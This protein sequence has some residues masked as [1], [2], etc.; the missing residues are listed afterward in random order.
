MMD[1]VSRIAKK[2]ARP[3]PTLSLVGMFLSIAAPC[4]A[5][6]NC[7]V[8]K[9]EVPPLPAT[10]QNPPQPWNGTDTGIVVDG[11]VGLTGVK[12]I[13]HGVDLSSNN[14]IN[15]DNIIRCGGQFAFLRLD[16]SHGIDSLYDRHRQ[17]LAEHGWTIFP[18]AYFALPANLRMS[19]KYASIASKDTPVIESYM[20]TFSHVGETA[21][22]DFLH[23]IASVAMPEIAFSGIT[24][25]ILA[26]DVEEKL[27]DE[28][29]STS[30]SRVYYGRFYA[31]A[32]CSW[33][34]KVKQT[35]PAL[36]P[37]LYTTPSIFGDYLN[38]ALPDEQDCLHG[39]PIWL[40]RTTADG[41]DVI[42]HSDQAIDLYAQRLC[43]VSG[44]NRCIVHQYSHR[45]MIG[46]TAPLNP[47]AFP[48]VDLDRLFAVKV[49]PDGVNQQVVRQ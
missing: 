7:P 9:Y 17:I 20:Q 22:D 6:E 12:G 26:V 43:N 49:V 37:I 19:Q 5:S 25:Q 27:L 23:R 2:L 35:Y 47:K 29:N 16:T 3:V 32:L 34:A 24:G 1:R 45:G 21:A 14:V 41:G 39:L 11:F 48:H 18:Y 4:H 28:G 38:Y 42:R 13:S 44:G 10:I 8:P 33:L 40:A 30:L 31:R 15:Y 46:G 36:R